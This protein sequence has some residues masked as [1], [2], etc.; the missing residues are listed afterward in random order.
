M[1]TIFI[2]NITVTWV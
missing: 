1:L 2:K